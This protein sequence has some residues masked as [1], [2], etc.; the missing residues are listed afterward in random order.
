MAFTAALFPMLSTGFQ[1]VSS[2]M[3]GQQQA[4][5][6]NYN[7]SILN[8]NARIERQ[9]ADARE[10]AK[11]RETAMVLGSQRAAFA[12]AGAGLDGSAADVMLQSATNAELDSMM[13][14]Y[15]GDLR[16]R[17][18]K[19]QARQERLSGK[20]AMTQGYFNAAGSI[21]GGVGDYMRGREDARYRSTMLGRM[22]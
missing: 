13:I 4:A 15:E 5:M 16:A 11:R 9:Q 2:I 21:L 8:Q 3:Q 12:Q 17:G 19:E 22:A 18:L 1:V 6:H 10:E 14:R 7:A 20:T